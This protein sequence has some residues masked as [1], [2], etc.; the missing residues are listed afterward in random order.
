MVVENYAVAQVQ[1]VY[2]ELLKY[3]TGREYSQL[4]LIWGNGRNTKPQIFECR[5]KHPWITALIAGHSVYESAL[6]S[7]AEVTFYKMR[8]LR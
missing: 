6:A 1:N 3:W 5:A 8:I 7:E 4:S 2:Q